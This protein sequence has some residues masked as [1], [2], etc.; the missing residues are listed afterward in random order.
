MKTNN[1]VYI[2]QNRTMTNSRELSEFFEK[3]HHNVLKAIESAIEDLSDPEFSGVN[4]HSA[5]YTDEQGKSRP[6]Y[7]LTQDAFTLVAMGFKGKR[8]L[9]F[10][11]L[12]IQEFNRMS[13]ELEARGLPTVP[14]EELLE[15]AAAELR[16]RDAIIAEHKS[17]PVTLTKTCAL[18]SFTIFK[19]YPKIQAEVKTRMLKKPALSKYG[20]SGTTT[21]LLE[22]KGLAQLK[23]KNKIGQYYSVF[24]RAAVE[25]VEASL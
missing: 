14:M 12:Y 4:F 9:T 13:A 6:M 16:K 25:R 11:K 8:A 17:S 20:T 5:N 15:L 2:K 23:A 18:N 3:E 1:L 22:E 7:E 24:D 21:M 19:Q 10:K